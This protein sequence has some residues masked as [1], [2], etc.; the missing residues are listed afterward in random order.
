MECLRNPWIVA[1]HWLLGIVHNCSSFYAFPQTSAPCQSFSHPVT[2]VFPHGQI[3]VGF[4][5]PSM[6]LYNPYKKPDVVLHVGDHTIVSQ[7]Q[8]IKHPVS[9]PFEGMSPKVA[10]KLQ[11]RAGGEV[12]RAFDS[13]ACPGHAEL[14][15]A[16]KALA[17]LIP[18]ASAAV[19]ALRP[20]GTGTGLVQLAHDPCGQSSSWL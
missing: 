15:Q 14:I 6:S 17:R 20:A 16:A 5:R 4:G 10:L 3:V 1:C 2:N 9:P 8:C 12:Q 7:S 18:D 13:L 11:K 19:R